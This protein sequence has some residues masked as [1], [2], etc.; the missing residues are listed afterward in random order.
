MLTV[1][2]IAQRE[3]FQFASKDIVM[4]YSAIMEIYLKIM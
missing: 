4:L 3:N 2:I 1:I